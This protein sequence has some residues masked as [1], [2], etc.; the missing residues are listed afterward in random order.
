MG[1]QGSIS[2]SSNASHPNPASS[3]F[4]EGSYIK[5]WESAMFQLYALPS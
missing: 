4:T 3:D 1:P 2:S 5:Y